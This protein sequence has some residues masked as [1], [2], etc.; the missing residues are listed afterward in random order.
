MK[1]SASSNSN[2]KN[3]KSKFKRHQLNMNTSVFSEESGTIG[4]RPD[5]KNENFKQRYTTQELRKQNIIE[6]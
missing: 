4:E 3:K 5:P 1:D 2:I 6:K